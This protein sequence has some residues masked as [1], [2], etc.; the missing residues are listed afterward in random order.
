[1]RKHHTKRVAIGVAALSLLLAGSAF[2]D[3]NDMT[4]VDG[5]VL[6]HGQT[7]VSGAT[8]IGL[9]YTL[10]STGSTVTDVA[11]TLAGDTSDSSAAIGFNDGDT[12][13]CTFGTY[14]DTADESSYDCTGLT[15]DTSTLTSTE[16]VVN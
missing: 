9:D 11:L 12:T 3:S 4:G 2:T 15:Q 14:D 16:V 6:G 8:V 7:T 1:M 13:D 5:G 10:D